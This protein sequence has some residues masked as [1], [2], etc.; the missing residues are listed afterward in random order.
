MSLAGRG[1]VYGRGPLKR[2]LD[3]GVSASALVVLAPLGLL[4]ALIVFVAS[5]RPILFRQERVGLDG[6]RFQIL[7]FRTM[8]SDGTAGLSITGRRDARVTPL[9]RLLRAAKVDE[10]PQFL[11]ILTGE[12]SLVGPRPEV[13]RY[14]AHYT[15][16]QRRVL[17]V[18]PGLTDPASI[19]F[20][21]EERLLGEVEESQRERFY[22]ETLLPRKLTISL[23]YID[24]AGLLQDLRCLLATLLALVGIGPTTSDRAGSR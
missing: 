5:G 23:H 22:V 6:R 15:E 2:A 11:N 10:I 9:G 20:R 19:E 18:R 3:L 12:M 8:R 24:R 17:E 14:V 4:V 21:D 1:P 13:P 7:K 16:T